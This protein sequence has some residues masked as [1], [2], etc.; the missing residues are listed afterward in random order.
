M[1]MLKNYLKIALRN[2]LKNKIYS[3]I[4]IV[5]FAA[6]MVG[7]ILI[8]WWVQDELSYD[9]FHSN[10]DN[11]YRVILEKQNS[12]ESVRFA[13]TPFPLAAALKAEVPE[14]F[15]CTRLMEIEGMVEYG[16]KKFNERRVFLVES[17]F[18]KMFT[19]PFIKG[20][21]ETALSDTYSVVLTEAMAKKYFGD[22]DPLGKTINVSNR[23]VKVTGVIKNT[24]L[25]SHLQFDFLG[26]LK[27]LKEFGFHM[28]DWEAIS[29]HTYVLVKKGISYRDLNAKIT[30]VLKKYQPESNS[31]L[32]LQPLKKIHLYSNFKFDMAG[33][34]DIKYVYIFY[35]IAVFILLIACINFMNLATARSATRGKEVGIRK[36]VGA[37]KAHLIKQFLNES[38]LFSMVAI[39][40]AVIISEQFLPVFRSITGKQLS[41]INSFNIYFILILVLLALF[42]GI[43]AGLYPAFFLSSFQ[44]SKVLK[45]SWRQEKGGKIALFRH[46]L[47]IFQFTISILL[48]ICT[49]VVS[50]Q[51]N[52]IKSK[53]LGFRKEN[54]IYMGMRKAYTEYEYLRGELLKNSSIVGIAATNYLPI[55]LKTGI[56][57]IHWEGQ[58][59]GEKIN[60][61]VR[62]VDYDYLDTFKMK[63]ADGRFFSKTYSTDFSESYVVNE[64]GVKAMGLEAPIGKW[65][66]VKGQKGK[67]I[68][69]LKDFHFTSLH[70][71][72]EPMIL[73]IKSRWYSYLWVRVNPVD[74]P[75]TIDFLK[76]K[77]DFIDKGWPFEYHFLDESIG[78]LYKSEQQLNKI[79]KY[80]TWL[81]IIICCLGLFGLS[82]FLVER[83]T[84]EI[85]IRKLLGASVS[86]IVLLLSKEL[87]RWVIIAT[88]I[89]WPIAYF[90]MDKW[91][92]DFAYRIFIDPGIFIF[93]ALITIVITLLTIGYQV[94]KAANT[95]PAKIL[96]F[97]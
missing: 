97:E 24:P 43:I 18:F 31:K 1:S 64:T 57:D 10:S 76:S 33:H 70:R 11:L 50:K 56:D 96:K 79:F 61:Q 55:Q 74:I 16:G 48:M 95:N 25:N 83:R 2:I 17:S 60:A 32:F 29:F 65:L 86:T 6:G 39:I 66:T 62:S 91:L 20:N 3:L 28:D 69:V 40:F 12:G 52:Y 34:G 89:T 81:A 45:E 21:P 53:D 72:I 49:M 37:N 15:D 13:L 9:R 90:M 30:Q 75:G 41:F 94:V 80:F 23:F 82:S 38:I 54:L 78:S 4:T 77:W 67:I 22:E 87:S 58:K 35:T 7:F 47:V 51:L 85:G 63:M 26:S 92:K 14:I 8:F 84:K 44:S 46:I 59:S 27:A 93:S 73:K 68:G 36:A 19:F 5:G 42:T 71:A 88:V